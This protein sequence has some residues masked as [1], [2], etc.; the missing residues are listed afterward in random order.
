MAISCVL[1]QHTVILQC[2]SPHRGITVL[3]WAVTEAVP[4]ILS[5]GNGIALK[6]LHAM[7]HDVNH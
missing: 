6:I 2:F 7:E 1:E 3:Q 4:D 5:T